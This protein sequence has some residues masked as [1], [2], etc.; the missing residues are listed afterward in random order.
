LF[1]L[2]VCAG[3]CIWFG[4]TKEYHID[5]DVD[6]TTI[7]NFQNIEAKCANDVRVVLEA[8]EHNKVVEF[9]VK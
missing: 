2:G 3:F 9:S 1:I 8:E 5:G 6:L 7:N 4:I